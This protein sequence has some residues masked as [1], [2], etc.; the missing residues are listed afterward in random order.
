[1]QS[2][3]VITICDCV[4]M[5]TGFQPLSLKKVECFSQSL[6]DL[7]SV[8]KNRSQRKNNASS[9][10]LK[11]TRKPGTTKKQ[12]TVAFC[13]SWHFEL[14]NRQVCKQ[15]C[16]QRQYC[17]APHHLLQPQITVQQKGGSGVWSFYTIQRRGWVTPFIALP[18]PQMK[19]S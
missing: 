12:F 1:M 2:D 18:P 9:Y 11:R 14:T 13:V 17:S 10:Q 4:V 7:A 19:A 8:F 15:G 5:L 16:S 3:D 6:K